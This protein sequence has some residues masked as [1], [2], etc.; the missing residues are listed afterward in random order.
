MTIPNSPERIPVF[1]VQRNFSRSHRGEIP[2]TVVLR[3]YEVYCHLYG[4][5]IAMVTGECR[6]GFAVTELLAFLYAHSF[7]KNEWEQRVEEAFEG[8]TL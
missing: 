3:A 5:Q 6:G 7:P 4:P 2:Q 1:P 8:M